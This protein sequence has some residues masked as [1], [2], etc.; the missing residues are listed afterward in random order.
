MFDEFTRAGSGASEAA[1][2]HP[3]LRETSKLFLTT[4]EFLPAVKKLLRETPERA[5]FTRK[6]DNGG[7][8]LEDWLTLQQIKS[9]PFDRTL[10]RQVYATAVHNKYVNRLAFKET[11]IGIDDLP[12]DAVALKTGNW[13]IP[14]PDVVHKILKH[15]STVDVKQADNDKTNGSK[16]PWRP[17]QCALPEAAPTLLNL[18]RRAAGHP[19]RRLF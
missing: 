16:L 1:E 3:A 8:S 5:Y 17:E 12:R 14:A 6:R 13:N 7:M 2:L 4:K 9:A 11:G 10:F 15:L 18:P 19:Q